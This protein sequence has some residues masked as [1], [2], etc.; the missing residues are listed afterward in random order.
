M[1]TRWLWPF[2]MSDSL[3]FLCLFGIREAFPEALHRPSL[4]CHWPTLSQSFHKSVIDKGI[5]WLW[6]AWAHQ[7]GAMY[8]EELRN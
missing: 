8:D 3:G 7:L 5:D 1:V 6:V 2:Q 4:V